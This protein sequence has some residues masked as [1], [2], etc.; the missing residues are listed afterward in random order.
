MDIKGRSDRNAKLGDR[1]QLWTCHRKVNQQFK[2]KDGRLTTANGYCVGG[3]VAHNQPLKVVGCF[4][5]E[6]LLGWAAMSAPAD[7]TPWVHGPFRL[8]NRSTGKCLDIH[9]SD[10]RLKTWTC[11]DGNRNQHFNANTHRKVGFHYGDGPFW[12]KLQSAK[13]GLCYMNGWGDDVRTKGCYAN[14]HDHE[15]WEFHPNTD[16]TFCILNL[17]SRRAMEI[18][19][20]GNNVILRTQGNKCNWDQRFFVEP[21][22]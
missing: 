5:M 6:N 12:M 19:K 8:R 15:V 21:V 16:G 2:I 22:N 14:P 9:T 3:N 18:K 4:S 1:L 11:K 17:Y 13:T 7:L 20:Q 10:G